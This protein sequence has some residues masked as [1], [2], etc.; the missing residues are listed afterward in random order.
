MITEAEDKLWLVTVVWSTR[1]T[2]PIAKT[3]SYFAWT[4]TPNTSRKQAIGYGLSS[5]R[6]LYDDFFLPYQVVISELS[7]E[8]PRLTWYSRG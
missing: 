4:P 7:Q 2:T 6:Q 3:I 1:L 8:P 5:L